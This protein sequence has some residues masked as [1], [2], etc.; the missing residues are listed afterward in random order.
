ML[1][2]LKNRGDT[3]VIEMVKTGLIFILL[4]F[5]GA[6]SYSSEINYSDSI[7]ASMSKFSTEEKIN[8]IAEECWSIRESN[9]RQAIQLG[10]LALNIALNSK[11]QK[12]VPE[13]YNYIGA[14][15]LNYLH[16]INNSV[17]FLEKAL[18][19]SILRKDSIELAYAYNN[20][21]DL[22]FRTN[23]IPLALKYDIQSYDIFT[24]INFKRGICYS[25]TNLGEAY[26]A[27]KEFEKS[28][29]YFEILYEKEK[30]LNNIGGIAFST[31]QIGNTYFKEGN[32]EK[33]ELYFIKAD[34]ISE[35]F[36]NNTF[37]AECLTGL[38]KIKL[39]KNQFKQAME[40]VQMA[41]ELNIQ[42]SYIPGIIDNKLDLSILLAN[43]GNFTLSEKLLNEAIELAN[44]LE[45]PTYI[46]KAY[47]TKLEFN[48]LKNIQDD[49]IASYQE[50][51]AIY[52]SLYILQSTESLNE[53]QQNLKTQL[54]MEKFQ[55]DMELRLKYRKFLYVVIAMLVLIGLLFYWRF[56]TTKILN[57]KLN[58]TNNTKDKLFSVIAHDLK[59]PFNAI[60]GLSEILQQELEQKNYTNALHY[61]SNLT[62]IS[63]DLYAL[64][65]NLL[66]WSRAQRNIIKLEPENIRL[67]EII[68]DI[69][70]IQEAQAQSKNI[71]I[72]SETQKYDNIY[73][74][75]NSLFIVLSNLV[76]NAIKFSPEN[77]KILISANEKEQN[78][79]IKIKDEG[80]GMTDEHISTI[81]DIKNSKSTPGTKNEKGTGLG[82]IICKEFVERM[83]GSISVNSRQ[84]KGS[85]FNIELPSHFKV[86]N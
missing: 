68:E 17:P 28:R 27:K 11:Y 48:K 22:Y 61:S 25:L 52:D 7:L 18:Y 76:S 60:L 2:I 44:S 43:I 36:K 29:E 86:S 53:M 37:K 84:G 3:C 38:A 83:G 77:G 67:S 55:K 57:R 79:T 45:F 14:I 15:Y 24:K 35:R 62:K 56:R 10:N 63:H 8:A 32:Y 72:I 5:I 74:D 34:S 82:L 26:L 59:S 4:L 46:L 16:D 40:L 66:N 58:E 9:P 13:L 41:M 71:K 39:V 31:L 1:W 30:E 54:S 73:T 75:K 49:V 42:T 19:E 23:N 85:T 20:L 33:A 6:V 78:V 51:F 80:I 69:K 50:Y 65:N 64:I 12:K 47:K 21:G 70:K 81:F